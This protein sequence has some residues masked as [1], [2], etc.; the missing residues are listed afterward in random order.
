MNINDLELLNELLTEACFISNPNWNF[1]HTIDM[2]DRVFATRF[3]YL[4]IFKFEKLPQINIT[5]DLKQN[6]RKTQ[7][8]PTCHKAKY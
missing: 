7:K 4:Y 8:E 2:T 1:K 6:E 3:E 5:L